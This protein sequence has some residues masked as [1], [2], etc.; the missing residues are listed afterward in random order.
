[1]G[2]AGRGAHTSGR[3]LCVMGGCTALVGRLHCTE[4][5]RLRRERRCLDGAAAVSA[6][7]GAVSLYGGRAGSSSHGVSVMAG[8]GEGEG[9]PGGGTQPVSSW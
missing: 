4:G 7:R 1:M 6:A 3:G 8:A 9:V 5:G 2:G